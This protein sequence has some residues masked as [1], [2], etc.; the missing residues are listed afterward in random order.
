MRLIKADHD[1]AEKA[2]FPGTEIEM[3][4]SSSYLSASSA[5]M[6]LATLI[7]MVMASAAQAIPIVL[8]LSE[9]SNNEGEG[10]GVDNLELNATATLTVVG[11]TLTIELANLTDTLSTQEFDISAFV[12]S[13]SSDISA[14][15]LTSAPSADAGWSQ[16]ASSVG[17]FGTFD[18]GASANPD[19]VNNEVGLN[20]DLVN[21]GETATFIYSFVCGGAC[22]ETDFIQPSSDPNGGITFAAKFI[23]GG[24]IGGDSAW[25]G[26][27][28]SGVP[29][30]EPG[31]ASLIMLG[32]AGLGAYG[33]RQRA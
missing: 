13:T 17:G 27:T 11:T 33:R 31:T 18:D 29:I 10:N 32:L 4:S 23:N 16:G 12:F 21:A 30:P 22:D 8:T 20:P 24:S 7:A 26:T 25:G 5:S 6:V 15:T 28:S 14:L 19:L 1:L 9:V 3:T 2:D